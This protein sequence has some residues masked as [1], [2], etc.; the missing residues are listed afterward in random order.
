MTYRYWFAGLLICCVTLQ[1]DAQY[2]RMRK[3][4]PPNLLENGDFTDPKDPLN[5]WFY[6]FDHNK[7][8]MDNHKY[9]RVED[10]K[11]SSR[12]KVLCLDATVQTVC[13]NQGVMVYTKPIRFDPTKKYKISL[14]AKSVPDKDMFGQKVL[15]KAKKGPACRIY[16][17]GYRWHPRAQKSNDPDFLD[18]REEL[19]FQP[20][21]FDGK[22]VTGEFSHVPKTWKRVEKVIPTPGRSALQQKHLE[23]CC[24][25][26]L[27]I[28]AMDATGVDR[29][30]TGWLYI[31]DVKIQEIGEADKVELKAG[32]QTKG[33]DGRSW[34]QRGS[35][36]SQRKL[37][38]IGG[39]RPSS[40]RTRR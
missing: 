19:R 24:W 1:A 3:K 23:R 27:K 25:L 34:N 40:N 14:S 28:L 12:K 16:P 22:S 13:I 32:A 38:P 33:F 5:G 31:D 9:V 15:G 37:T 6:T 11:G 17:I 2:S 21:Y 29:C 39:P 20:L 26:M 4:D 35:S 30:N 7:H 8:Y 10:D 18:L 36:T